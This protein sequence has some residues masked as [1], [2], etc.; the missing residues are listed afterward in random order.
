M[1]KILYWK[2]IETNLQTLKGLIKWP[3]RRVH[4]DTGTLVVIYFN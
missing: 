2:K 3:L 1:K 4:C